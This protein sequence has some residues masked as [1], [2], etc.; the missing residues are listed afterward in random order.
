M[1]LKSFLEL[2]DVRQRF[3]EEFPKPKMQGRKQL[4]APP[5]ASPEHRSLVGIAFDYLLRFAVERLNP[6]AVSTSWLAEYPATMPTE[7]LF[8][9]KTGNLQEARAKESEL[10]KKAMQIVDRAKKHRAKFLSSGEMTDELIRCALRLAQLDLVYR[11]GHVPDDLGRTQRRDIQDLRQLISIVPL[12]LFKASRHCLLNPTFGAASL[13]V[14]GADADLV[15]D[16]MIIEIKT[17]KDCE[18]KRDHFNQ[19]IGYYILYLLEGGKIWGKRLDIRRVG[20]YFSRFAYLYTVEL[21]DVINFSRLT[22][23][24]KWF[25]RRAKTFE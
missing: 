16:D 24:R 20:I 5:L 17:I 9:A 10:K 4:L 22:K 13:L 25:E 2:P 18:L 21:D 3:R 8:F 14:G 6:N 12:K 11:A 7:R 15:I 23:F 1:S 19:L